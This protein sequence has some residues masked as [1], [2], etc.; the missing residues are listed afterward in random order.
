VTDFECLIRVLH[1]H[2][3][4]FVLVGGLAATVHVQRSA[5]SCQL[6]QEPGE[7]SR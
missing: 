2:G 4:S 1:D 6:L 7:H 3:V 5:V